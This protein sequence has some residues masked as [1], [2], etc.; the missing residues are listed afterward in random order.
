VA[1]NSK[2]VLR[3]LW[4]GVEANVDKGEGVKSCWNCMDVI[5]G[6]L[7]SLVLPLAVMAQWLSDWLSAV[8]HGF[9][10]N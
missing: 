9:D 3:P 6:C 10:F 2:L 7:L 5:N 1:N 4:S 8:R